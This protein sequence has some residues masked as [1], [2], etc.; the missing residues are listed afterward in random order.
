[1]PT[2]L[3]NNWENHFRGIPNME[4]SNKTSDELMQL[5][6][7]ESSID[8]CLSNATEEKD[9]VFMVK[10][11][12][13]NNIVFL[14][15]IS[16][17]GGTRTNKNETIFALMGTS[18]KALPAQ[19]NKETL[20]TSFE[21]KTPTWTAIY[22]A[23]DD[24]DL[25]SLPA[26]SKRTFRPCIPLPPFLS[27]AFIDMG[28]ASTIDLLEEAIRCINEYDTTHAEDE[29][30]P[31]AAN[32]LQLIPL[33]LWAAM[34][35]SFPTVT[36]S[37]S[38][39][40]AVLDRSDEIHSRWILSQDTQTSPTPSLPNS[41]ALTQ[42]ASN[43]NEQT[44]ILQQMNNLAEDKV[45]DKANTK[46]IDAIHPSFKM[47][48]LAASSTDGTDPSTSPTP[49]CKAFFDQKSA[50]HA[51]IHLLHTLTY[52]FGC[53]VE[54]SIPLTTALYHGNF[55][56]DKPDS[57][58]NFCSLLFGKP[59]PLASSGAKEAMILHLKAEKGNGWSDKDL[60]KAL[61]QTIAIPSTIDGMLHSIHYFTAAAHLFFGEDSLL[62][63]G[64]TTWRNQISSNLIN[65][66]SQSLNDPAFIAS[67]LTA[68]D[69]RVNCWLMDCATKPLR[70]NVDDELVDFSDLQK[71]IRIRQFSFT[72]PPS[73]RSHI[74]SNKRRDPPSNDDEGR[75]QKRQPIQNPKKNSRWKLREG[76]DYRKVFADKHIDKRPSVNGVNICPRWHIRGVC[77][78]GCNLKDTHKDISDPEIRRQMDAYCKLCRDE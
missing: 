30:Y 16:K 13:S 49:E 55:L 17:L 40:K 42:L 66:E 3:A 75:E 56:W 11:P 37:T 43:I 52:T 48:I 27:T 33:W 65:Y 12:F 21:A 59:S 53:T 8:D 38:T 36:T 32:V 5:F 10:A 47:M 6:D 58:N 60:E 18:A 76:E 28:G 61:K 69:T 34:D 14:H 50:A 45:R 57:P 44:I 78:T 19:T 7:R 4:E 29:A 26:R 22:D 25:K 20:F 70:C 35:E 31:K 71:T 23:D 46:G 9:T 64:L 68:I 62:T 1:M 73:I 77:F 2:S 74:S 72:L 39:N 41:E 24:M 63:S 15:H 51:K 67:V 54:I